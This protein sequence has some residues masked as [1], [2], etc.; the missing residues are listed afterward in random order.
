VTE[1]SQSQSN[2]SNNNTI[3]SD[4]KDSQLEA[5][6]AKVVDQVIQALPTKKVA[7]TIWPKIERHQR[8]GGK[9]FVVHSFLAADNDMDILAIRHLI[10][11]EPYLSKHGDIS[12]AWED[13]VSNIN[14][15]DKSSPGDQ[16]FF[17]PLTTKMLKTRF[18]AYMKFVAASK[19]S[20]PFHS[21]CDDKEEACKIQAGIEE[22]HE[23]FV[24][25]MDNKENKKSSAMSKKK[26][27]KRAADIIRRASLGMKPTDKE[28]NDCAYDKNNKGKKARVS[29]MSSISMSD[30]GLL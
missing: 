28:L 8:V 2:S 21:G 20:V 14:A 23:K 1:K 3:M 12:K 18:D 19:A 29:S 27:E 13:C 26:N 25:F 6:Y 9:Q 7:R 22:M 4:S 5:E 15:E 17:P 11:D 16:I 24:A 10:V 30:G